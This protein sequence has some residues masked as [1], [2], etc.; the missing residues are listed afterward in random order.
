MKKTLSNPNSVS[1]ILSRTSSLRELGLIKEAVEEYETLFATNCPPTEIISGLM[2][3]LSNTHSPSKFI[4]RIEE[5]IGSQDLSDRKIVQIKFSLGLE[6]QRRGHKDLA[7]DLYK[8]AAKIDP[9]NKQIEDRINQLISKLSPASRY[10]YLLNR[11]IVTFEQLKEALAIS[12]KTKKS[13]EFV[14]IENFKLRKE[15][16]GKSL[17]LFYMCPFKSFDPNFPVPFELIGKLKK[18]FLLHDLWVPLVWG[19]NRIE[20]LIDNPNDLRK[21]GHIRGL[22]KTKKIIYSVGIKEDIE[23]FISLFFDK[24]IE[25]SIDDMIKKLDIIPDISFEEEEENLLEDILDETSS[26]TIKF[27]DQVIINA[28][29][30]NA[31]DIHIEP[32]TVSKN[33]DIRFRLDGVCHEF[34]QVPN[35]MAKGI[36]SRL[37]IMAGL[38]IAERRLPQDGKIKFRRKGAPPFELRLATIP[39]TGG[40]EDAVLRLLPGAGVMKLNDMGLS[41]RDLRIMKKILSQ[42]YGLILVVGPTGSGKTTSLHSALSHINNPG[43]KIWTAEDPVEITQAGLRQVEVKP[44]IGLDFARVLRSFLRTDPDVIMIG[45]MRDHETASIG[46][47]A[48]LTGHLVFST[49]HT[50]NA[51]ETVTRLLDMGLN[52]LNFS[53]AFLGVLAQRLIRKLCTNCRRKYHPSQGAFQEIAAEYGEDRFKATNIEYTPDL[54]LFSPGKCEVCSETGY[55]G[56]IGIYELLEGTS[57]IKRLIKKQATTEDI[58][59][60]AEDEGMTTLKQDGIHKVF[61]GLTDINEIRR[62]CID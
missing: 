46:I 21:T 50:N 37:K 26:Q 62:V 17:S 18:S 31:S 40:H 20:I 47:E 19:K 27:V 38:D 6:M 48:S 14:L 8:A 4:A 58:F 44:K 15:D 61:Y 60:Q 43:I 3:C 13:V 22:T 57:Q 49:L 41:E 24:K 59:L 34:V 7:L 54:F 53:D 30:K 25:E 56:R 39:T 2:E 16:V 51:A 10:D 1:E 23:E 29:Q 35:S 28:Y 42:P 32:S 55:K 36:I 5:T 52:P 45:E 12:K 11:G 33:T 9:K